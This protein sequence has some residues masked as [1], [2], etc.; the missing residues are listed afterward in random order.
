MATGDGGW[1]PSLG[2]AAAVVVAFHWPLLLND[3]VYFED[4]FLFDWFS[5]GRKDTFF[6]HLRMYGNLIPAYFT[7][8]I[9]ELPHNIFFFKLI[10]FG[11][12]L[13]ASIA[14]FGMLRKVGYFTRM[15]AAAIAALAA[16]YPGHLNTTHLS[17]V[18]HLICYAAYWV[19]VLL[20]LESSIGSRRLRLLMRTSAALL[21]FLAFGLNSLLVF[22]FGFIA[23]LLLRFR[24]ESGYKYARLARSFIAEYWDV[25]AIPF[26][27][28]F[29][30]Q[31][32]VVPYGEGA[33]HTAIQFDFFLVARIYLSA[34]RL[35]VTQF[36][37]VGLYPLAFL[38]I[39]A[40]VL[41]LLRK[42]DRRL[43]AVWNTAKSNPWAVFCFALLLIFLGIFP[44]A[45]T[46]R[47]LGQWASD[48]A[49]RNRI[50]IM[51]PMALLLLSGLA[52]LLRRWPKI[53]VASVIALIGSFGIYRLSVYEIWEAEAIKNHSIMH[54]LARLKEARE[55]HVFGVRDLVV[56]GFD[57]VRLPHGY[58]SLFLHP[59]NA[60]KLVFGD[61]TRFVYFEGS[62]TEGAE[63][64]PWYTPDQA[65]SMNPVYFPKSRNPLFI[66]ASFDPCARQAAL[67][68]SPGADFRSKRLL[69]SYYYFKFLQPE[70]MGEFLGSLTVLSLV[71]RWP[72]T[73]CT[74][75]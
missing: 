20:V 49:S 36:F 27:F 31:V 69:A 3:G 25:L 68:I 67:V 43:E 1:L 53:Y 50:L 2:L 40:T 75:R 66:P 56:D 29:W 13:I 62:S 48:A 71:P 63:R 16:V 34:A 10:A 19:A 5:D 14:I 17:V 22:H 65:Q 41:L 54:N 60:F 8:A 7:W 33:L 38:P 51:L 30:R 57:R 52:I 21:F 59:N 15:Q 4:F 39:F 74:A 44:Y 42:K 26:V 46:D 58:S 55:V 73:S 12:I 9:F 32:I 28:W 70:R 37:A 45:V 35:F 47:G 11:S 24:Q 18:F 23:L 6:G 72:P 61:F 64:G